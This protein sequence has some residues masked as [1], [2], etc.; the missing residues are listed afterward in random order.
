MDLNTRPKNLSSP[1]D[2]GA[3]AH[4]HLKRLPNLSLLATNNETICS[5]DI[6][7]VVVFYGYPMKGRPDTPLP[8]SWEK[9][10]GARGCT[11]QSYSF[12]DQYSQLQKH[13]AS[14]YGVSVQLR[15]RGWSS[16]NG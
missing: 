16:N 11:P 15:Q 2:D 12:Q 3:A 9:V 8:E 4:L 6:L 14:V 7:G 10:P 1:I 5:N 13:N